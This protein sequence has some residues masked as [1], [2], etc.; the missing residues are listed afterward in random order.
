[1]NHRS[2]V[3]LSLRKEESPKPSKDITASQM[4]PDEFC[5]A[6]RCK[7]HVHSGAI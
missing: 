3:M 1:M 2:Q 7:V 4:R 5:T 6:E